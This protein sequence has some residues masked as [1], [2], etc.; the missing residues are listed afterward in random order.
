MSSAGKG[1]R[2]GQRRGLR[3]AK[4]I[5]RTMQ[6]WTSPGAELVRLYF[7]GNTP[8]APAEIPYSWIRTPAR[9]R[10][11]TLIN[12]A[13]VAQTGGVTAR[14][15]DAE[16]IRGFGMTSIPF[17]LDCADATTPR[18]LADFTVDLLATQPAEIP[19]TRIAELTLVPLIER[20][21]AEIWRILD[22]KEGDRITITNAPAD[23]PAG[24]NSLVIVGIAHRVTV[25]GR[26]VTW[27]TTPV[28][29][30]VAGEPGPWFYTDTSFTGAT[31]ETPF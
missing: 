26:I 30:R 7:F 21:D 6:G 23:W 24:A 27:R 16:S 1:S 8:P 28:L 12:T 25:E 19:R 13:V 3:N 5:P 10:Q 17:T 11:D 9:F 4:L 22:R 15:R 2:L 29:G 18:L 31:D 14:A 20:T